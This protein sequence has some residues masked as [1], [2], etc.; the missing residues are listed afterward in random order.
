[1][2]LQY[3]A[4]QVDYA[5]INERKVRL[6]LVIALVMLVVRSPLAISQFLPWKISGIR[7]EVLTIGRFYLI[8][9]MVIVETGCLLYSEKPGR[10]R[11]TCDDLAGFFNRAMSIVCLIL[12]GISLFEP[13]M[14]MQ[15]MD[16]IQWNEISLWARLVIFLV[17][18]GI[19]L[20]RFVRP[21]CHS[22]MLFWLGA[23][24]LLLSQ[25]AMLTERL[26]FISYLIPRWEKLVVNSDGKNLVLAY[27]SL[28]RYVNMGVDVVQAVSAGLLLLEI[29]RQKPQEI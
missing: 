14:Q 13:G 29:F 20:Y 26:I 8:K 23:I 15:R 16:E 12:L 2:K 18:W 28:Y 9:A 21:L 24:L 25:L 5:A 7:A 4:P 19:V 22:S 1:M 27:Y 17:C 11:F 10:E 6:L 3:L